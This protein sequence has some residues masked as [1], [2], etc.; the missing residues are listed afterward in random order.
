MKLL[1]PLLVALMLTACQS[2]PSVSTTPPTELV[3][4]CP[5]RGVPPIA[6]KPTADRAT[7]ARFG[8]QL[9]LAREATDRAL[10]TCADRHAKLVAWV[11]ATLMQQK[12]QSS[13]K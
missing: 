4:A 10:A 1:L 2:A 3:E 13:W 8:V 6:P 11:A 9:Q 5:P 7:L 12:E